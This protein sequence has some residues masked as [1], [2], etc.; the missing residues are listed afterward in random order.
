MLELLLKIFFI[1]AFQN[2]SIVFWTFTRAIN[3]YC[4]ERTAMKSANK[5]C[6]EAVKCCANSRCTVE[7]NI[8]V[9]TRTKLR[10]TKIN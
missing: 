1:E 3:G 10:K 2:L 4:I 7:I 5:L 6:K 8:P 9:K